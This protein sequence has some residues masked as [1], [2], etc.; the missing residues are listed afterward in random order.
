MNDDQV[1]GP[2]TESEKPQGFMDRFL[3]PAKD[4]DDA[5]STEI[6]PPE[7]RKAAMRV[8]NRAEIR[9]GYIAAG[10]A[11]IFSLLL[12]VP[13]MFG[14]S[15]VKQTAKI[16]NGKCPATYEL[17]KGVCTHILIR[18]PSYYI[19]PLIIYLIFCLAIFITVRVRRRVPASFA[20][21]LAGA[22]FTS[23]SIAIGAP[24]LIYGGWLF[25]RARRIQKYGT[26]DSKT[27]ATIAAEQRAARKDGTAPAPQR[28]SAA[29]KKSTKGSTK[30]STPQASKRYT[31]PQPKRKKPPVQDS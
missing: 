10:I 31:P 22:A 30:S 11:F 17:V 5:D 13:F 23:T 18:Q 20:S 3:K 28:G 14:P 19:L 24:L 2:E 25:V 1:D 8:M 12:T 9:L 21:F 6:I 15:Q 27:V 4:R 26:T 7:D 29:S 16:S